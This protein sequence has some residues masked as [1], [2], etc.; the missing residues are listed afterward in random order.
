MGVCESDNSQINNYNKLKIDGEIK[1][2]SIDYLLN[3]S[4]R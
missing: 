3:N 1:D 2:I 4:I